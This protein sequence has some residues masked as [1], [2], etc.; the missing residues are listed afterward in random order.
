M[1]ECLVLRL[2]LTTVIA[3]ERPKTALASSPADTGWVSKQQIV[4]EHLAPV[5]KPGGVG[6]S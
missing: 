6:R 5:T 2:Q 3:V 4:I 1:H